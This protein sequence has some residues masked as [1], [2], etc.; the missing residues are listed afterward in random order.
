VDIM[1][2]SYGYRAAMPGTK[3]QTLLNGRILYVQ[4]E[5][6]NVPVRWVHTVQ[7]W[8]SGDGVL[9]TGSL[10]FW[11]VSTICIIKWT[12]F[13]CRIW[14]HPE[15]ECVISVK[16]CCRIHWQGPKRQEERCM[17]I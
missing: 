3:K 17:V 13:E 1:L 10:D 7:S 4:T 16:L 9:Y 14:F 6:Q 5:T 8:L 2:F 15:A 12:H 11:A